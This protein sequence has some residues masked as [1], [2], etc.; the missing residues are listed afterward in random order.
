MHSSAI[1]GLVLLLVGF[2]VLVCWVQFF[3]ALCRQPPRRSAPSSAVPTVAGGGMDRVAYLQLRA[4]HTHEPALREA[5]PPV[6]GQDLAS[7][8]DGGWV[9]P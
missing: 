7:R 1:A 4:L 9:R 8:A 5:L 6:G 3:L 2:T